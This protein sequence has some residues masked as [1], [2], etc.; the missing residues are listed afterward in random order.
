MMRRLTCH[1]V[2]WVGLLGTPASAQTLYWTGT[3]KIQRAEVGGAIED[4]VLG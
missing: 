3:G 4:L 2:V 1:D